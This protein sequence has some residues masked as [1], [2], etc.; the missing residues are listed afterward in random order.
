MA[1]LVPMTPSLT[2]LSDC[3]QETVTKT[4]AL[5]TQLFGVLYI[6]LTGLVDCMLAP[7]LWWALPSDPTAPLPASNRAPI[8]TWYPEICF[9]TKLPIFLSILSPRWMSVILHG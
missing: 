7:I 2:L 4:D 9:Q 6:T 5:S 8:N 3:P 1:Y